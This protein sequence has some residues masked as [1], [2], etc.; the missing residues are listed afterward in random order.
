MRILIKLVTKELLVLEVVLET[1]YRTLAVR[2]DD[3]ITT[4]LLDEAV[5][6]GVD[7]CFTNT[8]LPP[9]HYAGLPFVQYAFDQI[10]FFPMS[11]PTGDPPVG[12]LTI[13]VRQA[14]K[15]AREDSSV[16]FSDGT[17]TLE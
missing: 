6:D 9:E 2:N 8:Q 13:S 15:L 10:M 11:P 3:R 14:R 16:G 5:E 7:N 4:C 1:T 12:I 17:F